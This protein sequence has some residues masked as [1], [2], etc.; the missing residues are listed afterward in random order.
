M[1][2]GV[3]RRIAA[4]ALV[5]VL[6]GSVVARSTAQLTAMSMYAT[7]SR[8]S[9][10]ERAS[11]IDPG[12]YRIHARLAQLYLGRG[13]CRRS[14]V[15]AGAAARLFPASPVARRLLGACG[16]YPIR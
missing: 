2:L 8:A 12:S 10:L 5:T 9:V 14:R 7:N 16:A 3:A 1:D 11:A 4:V 6:G 15:H 13:D